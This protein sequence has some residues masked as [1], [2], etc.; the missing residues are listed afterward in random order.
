MPRE[1]PK[2]SLRFG[3]VVEARWLNLC[4]DAHKQPLSTFRLPVHRLPVPAFC[5]TFPL[6]VDL[7]SANPSV[8]AAA[9]ISL[10]S[11]FMQATCLSSRGTELTY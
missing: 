4:S 11:V 9:A 2:E 7:K 8:F 3:S 6:L 1:D 5:M 10:L